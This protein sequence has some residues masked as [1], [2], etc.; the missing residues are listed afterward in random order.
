M[1][2]KLYF[3]I[4]VLIFLGFE[5][6]SY[7]EENSLLNK[8]SVSEDI[9]QEIDNELSWI[10]EETL[11]ITARKRPEKLQDVPV[12][13]TALNANMIE[14]YQV[15]NIGDV[16]H[17]TPNFSAHIGDAANAVV[18]IRGIGQL[19]SLCF[20][21]PGVGIYY[22]DVYLARTQGAFLDVFDVERIE[23]LRGPQ[24]T[25]YGKNTIGGAV[26]Y[27][28]APIADNEVSAKIVAEAGSFYQKD[29]KGKISGPF[30]NDKLFG[31]LSFIS[32]NRKGF[33]ENNFDGED[34][35]D[36]KT[37]AGRASMLYKYNDLFSFQINVDGSKDHPFA[38]RTPAR[39]TSV[40]GFVNGLPVTFPASD[41]PFALDADYNT[42]DDLDTSGSS[43]VAIWNLTDSTSL[44][45]ITSYRELDY[46]SA[47]DLDST[48]LRILDV[49]YKLEQNQFSQELQFSYNPETRLK[50]IA[51]LYYF[52]EKNNGFDGIDLT[53][54]IGASEASLN[55]LKTRS[56]AVYG[57]ASYNIIDNLSINCGLRYT[58]EKKDFKRRIE[59]YQGSPPPAP[60]TTGVSFGTGQEILDFEAEDDWSSFSPKIGLSYQIKD[61]IL[62]YVSAAHGFKSGGFDGRARKVV[63][64][65]EPENLWSYE[66]GFK[67]IWSDN[68]IIVNGSF[69]YNDYSDLQ[70]SSF[71]ADA[72]GNFFPVFTNAGKAV[73]QGIE[74][75][76]TIRPV[77]GLTL[78]TG[79]GFIDAYYKKYI[80]KGG[81]DISDE[82]E[83]VNTPKWTAMLG[84]DYKCLV[85]NYGWVNFGGD[86]SFR[87]KTYLTV[88]SSDTLAQDS[89]E[90][91]N[92]FINF[93]TRDKH[94]LFTLAGKNLSDEEYKEHAF[95]LMESF[96]Y[97]LAYYGAPRTFS[98]SISYIF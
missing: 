66:T 70:L 6:T 20:A 47:I 34:D 25:L 16:Q 98:L 5:Q 12:S 67:S 1:L 39:E 2:K 35:G 95:D 33:S 31:K 3:I 74:L 56:Y 10:E 55:D 32:L 63:S 80:G 44:K 21:E 88:S 17:L 72:Q 77:K 59:F 7:S 27:I 29:I 69:F 91:Y 82:R 97:Q 54:L 13:V 96:G 58:K 23:V 75:E 79:L 71:S 38:S 11:V 48:H 14:K 36:K 43:V 86:A 30:I 76:A 18:Y 26:K 90:L 41:D 19:D 28:S 57:E 22:D 62:T 40:T 37:L 53:E 42:K 60:G 4:F 78:Q 89:Y 46:D 65:Y 73:T 50:G 81:K 84:L 92:A 68:R 49:F 94:W 85:K 8:E 87:S 9:L 61:N 93:E 15:E 83:F 64:S 51:G 45:S 52:Q 24:G